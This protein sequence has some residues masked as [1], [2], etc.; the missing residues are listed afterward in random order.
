MRRIPTLRTD[1]VDHKKCG[2]VIRKARREAG[3]TLRAVSQC[4]GLSVQYLS[5]LELGRRQWSRQLFEAVSNV[6]D[7]AISDD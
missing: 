3:L 5:A 2:D 1:T 7:S 4:S 6:I